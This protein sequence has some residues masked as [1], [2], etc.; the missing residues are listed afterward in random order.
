M[1]VSSIGPESSKRSVSLG[2]LQVSHSGNCEHK[3]YDAQDIEIKWQK[4]W[5]ESGIDNP[6]NDAHD[7]RTNYYCLEM[8]PYPSGNLHMGHVRNYCLGDAVARYKRMQGF[9]VLHPIGWDA[10]G[11]P[12]EN[13]AIK[14]KRPPAEWTYA[15]ID[16]MR[17]QL[18]RLGLSYDWSRE[19]ATCKPEY[20]RWEQWMFT[21]LME[22][23]LA[24]QKEAE[25]NWCD[26]C[27]TV[28][29]NEQVVDGVCWRCDTPVVKKNLKQWFIKI[30][31]YAEELLD[32]L[33]QLSGWPEKVVG[34]QRNWIGK[35]SGAEVSFNVENS[36]EVLD[37]FT[38]RPDTL[39]GVTYMA[40]AAAH[41]LAVKATENNAEL[42]VFLK[43]CSTIST[44]EADVATMEKKGMALG[45]NA[46]HPVT[47]ESIPVWVANF[48]LMGY[49][50]GAVMSVP[51]HDDRDY[52]FAKKYGLNIKQVITNTAGDADV[53]E[54]AYTD[55]GVLINSGEFDGLKSGKA[56]KTITHWLDSHD[57]GEE[58]IQYR[59]RDWLVSRQ[60]Y[61]GTPIPVIHCDDCGAV[62]VPEKDLPVVLPE[63][64][65][66]TGGSSPL[67]EC[68][69]FL[70]VDCPQ[71]GK[72]AQR[73]A[74]TF[75]TFMESS[76][77]M[78]RY[79]SARC[80]T[81]MVDAD[82]MATWAPVDQY[83]G[84]VEHAVLHLLYA[85]FYHKL[86]RDMGLFDGEKVGAEPFKNLLTQGMVLMDGTKMSKSKGNTV[87]PSAIIER[88]GCDTA[89]L[90]TLFAAPPE[91]DLEW[92]DSGVEGAH[93]FLNRVWRLFEKLNAD[94]DGKDDDKSVKDL[95]RTI[96]VTIEKVTRAFE[97]GFAFNVAIAAQMELA[98]ALQSFKIQGESG[99]TAF[100]EGLQALVKMLSPFVPHFACECGEKLGFEK[101]AV[102]MAWPEVDAE[103]L[104]QDEIVLVVQIQGKK[105]GEIMVPTGVDQDTALALAQA[106]SAVAKWLEG[107]AIVKVILVKGR[108]LNIV[109]RPA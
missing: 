93:R 42:A 62:A 82:A 1:F 22:K 17:G 2:E 19:I 95:R 24:Y 86:M 58:R 73:E 37:I 108:L 52:D 76:W 27:H 60:R 87:D 29:A 70:N 85:R 59:L 49:G 71:C 69:V 9:N 12:A 99:K 78:N 14:H 6:S 109:V 64:L 13:A 67:A 30:T 96:H 51:A 23:G 65:Q 47:G 18:K 36:D 4:Q 80:D 50:T 20:Y 68:E 92:E 8:F 84:G 26:P 88:Y 44:K 38:T 7:Q 107:M 32:D 34:M 43:E 39:M 21:K 90:F 5:A 100:V 55:A 15:N 66:P 83:I 98:N 97:H 81:A 25:V 72:P 40:V 103:A 35:S 104:V 54:A 56:K 3:H 46:I 11:L 106:D 79:I 53:S 89:R 28:L 102:I 31:D 105:R 16:Q 101:D 74:D 48:V 94:T 91:K 33:E 75:D 77:Y 61:W 57:K 45:V 10:F 63:D 41:P